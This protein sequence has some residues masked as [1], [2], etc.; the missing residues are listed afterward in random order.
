MAELKQHALLLMFIALLLVVKF[1]IIPV[2]DWQNDVLAKI[3]LLE[4]KQHKIDKVLLHKDDN[5]Q[6]NNQLTSVLKQ[7][8]GMFFPF[9][10][11]ANFK[12]NQQKMLESLLTKHNLTTQ[13]IGWKTSSSFAELDLVRYP[14]D[15]RF[16]G[17]TTDVIEFIAALEANKQR[18]EIKTF[19]LS[20]KGQREKSLGRINGNITL[21][22]FLEGNKGKRV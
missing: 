16:T 17:K 18:V 12:L 1:I 7:V 2:F 19:N 5:T 22:L 3:T 21:Y 15:I 9:Q 11:E 6:L 13:N 8:D 4:K 14:I 10:T 20:F